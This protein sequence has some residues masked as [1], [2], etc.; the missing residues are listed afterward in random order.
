MNKD[1]LNS[2]PVS[3]IL[4]FLS[5]PIRLE[6]SLFK[7]LMVQKGF[8]YGLEPYMPDQKV[9][10]GLAQ[11]TKNEQYHSFLAQFLS[12]SLEALSDRKY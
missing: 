5:L 3:T 8:E 11:N 12:A 9:Y 10:I 4:P 1:C 7:K 6:N 2:S